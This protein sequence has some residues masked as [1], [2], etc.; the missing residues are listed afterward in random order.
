M[1]TLKEKYEELAIQQKNDAIEKYCQKIIDEC[2][3]KI[4]QKEEY[5][6]MCFKNAISH[7]ISNGISNKHVVIY[8]NRISKIYSSSDLT[9]TYPYVWIP[10]PNTFFK[11][12]VCKNITEIINLLEKIISDKKIPKDF[13]LMVESSDT[14]FIHIGLTLF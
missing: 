3:K 4:W 2:V 10:K 13:K 7:N 11:V 1:T 8:L 12:Y 5:Y 9:Y 6:K 14:H